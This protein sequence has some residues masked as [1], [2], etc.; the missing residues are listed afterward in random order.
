MIVKINWRK[1]KKMVESPLLL[2]TKPIP[3]ADTIELR[4]ENVK[5]NT[6]TDKLQEHK[7]LKI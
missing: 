1:E 2:V 3:C 4:E 6:S 7:N 5:E